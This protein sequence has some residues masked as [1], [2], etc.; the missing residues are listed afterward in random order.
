MLSRSLPA[1]F[2]RDAARAPLEFLPLAGVAAL[3]LVPALVRRPVSAPR[4]V[5]EASGTTLAIIAL[6]WLG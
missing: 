5:V 3:L 4:L 2:L 6:F 1:C